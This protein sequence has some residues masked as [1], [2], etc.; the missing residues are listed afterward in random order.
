MLGDQ[1][2]EADLAFGVAAADGAPGGFGRKNGGGP[3]PV[4]GLSVHQTMAA[5]K[6]QRGGYDMFG[7]RLQQ[8][9]RPQ[10]PST[11]WLLAAC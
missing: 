1:V 5:Q 7:D 8:L 11:Y 2:G 3:P 6:S 10:N 4:A 9:V